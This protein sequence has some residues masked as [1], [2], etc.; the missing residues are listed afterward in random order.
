MGDVDCDGDIDAVDALAILQ[1]SV[2]IRSNGG[3]C[4]LDNNS[5]QINALAGDVNNS[6]RTTSADALL[7]LQCVAGV[8]NTF[9]SQAVQL[10]ANAVQA[11]GDSTSRVYLPHIE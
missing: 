8:S 10:D 7:V 1:Y 2:D 3:N 5:T 6:G 9:C 4:P 11:A